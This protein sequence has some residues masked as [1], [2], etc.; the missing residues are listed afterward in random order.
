MVNLYSIGLQVQLT[1]GSWFTVA[2]R[3]GSVVVNLG[4]MLAESTGWRVKATPHR[5][6][7][8]GKDRYT[9]PFFF[10]PGYHARFPKV[11]PTVVKNEDGTT[12]L[13]LDDDVEYITYG[14]WFRANLKKLC[15]EYKAL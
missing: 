8:L 10:E 11:L 15:A 3:P 14:P 2:P 13:M 4:K 9:A 5:V 6:L 7:D 1:D 12:S